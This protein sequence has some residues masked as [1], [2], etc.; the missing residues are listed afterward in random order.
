MKN[1]S[2]NSVAG[3]SSNPKK[4]RPPAAHRVSVGAIPIA[5]AVSTLPVS[6]APVTNGDQ[7]AESRLVRGLPDLAHGEVPSDPDPETEQAI[8]PAVWHEAWGDLPDA[9]YLAETLDSLA[10]LSRVTV[11]NNS[12]R[13]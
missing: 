8:W 10:F 7:T 6:S 1:S 11:R 4:P 12:A 13:S 9:E 5:D 3:G 2:K